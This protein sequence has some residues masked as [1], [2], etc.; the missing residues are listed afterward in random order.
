MIDVTSRLTP[1]LTGALLT[2][3]FAVA[4][5]MRVIAVSDTEVDTPLRADAAQYFLYAVNLKT[6]GVYSLA[7]NIRRDADLSD[8][9]SP[10][11]SRTPGYALF[12]LPF[13]DY[14]PSSAGLNALLFVQAVLSAV[15]SVLSFTLFRAFLPA[16]AA[17]VT[18]LLT[19]LSPHLIVANVYVL[20][21]TLFTLFLIGFALA[22]TRCLQRRSLPWAIACGLLLGA[23]MLV[24]P[25]L[26]YF[27]I[28]LIPTLGLLVPW[29]DVRRLGTAIVLACCLIYGP[30]IARNAIS[31]PDAAGSTKAIDSVHMGMYPNVMYRD[32]PETLG[33]PDRHDPE[34]ATRTTTGDV[35]AEIAR[36]FGEEPLRHMSWYAVG[37][38][39]TFFSWNMVVG[40]GDA[41]IYPVFTSPYH[42][43]LP[44]HLTR[45]LMYWLHW[46]LTALALATLFAVWLPSAGR[47]VSREALLAGR[48]ISIL[49]G[50]FVLVHVAGLPLPRY[51]IPLRPLLYGS[52]MLGLTAMF[53]ALRRRRDEQPPAG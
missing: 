14:P 34:W 47:Y 16:W 36:R 26:S 35:A 17:L 49:F 10:D 25:T 38:P 32:M 53:A 30:W 8:P 9:P 11:A 18:A 7:D 40:M 4:L 15:T 41:F 2:A 45:K 3:I 28:L 1:R 51:A 22:L 43:S 46:P 6:Y 21:E 31:V 20:T 5:V 48:A 37:K 33:Y 19:A 50:Y 24:R 39:L 52:A 29:R 13:V 12:M 27:L 44:F 42:T 23:T